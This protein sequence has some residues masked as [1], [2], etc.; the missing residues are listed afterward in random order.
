MTCKVWG[1]RLGLQNRLFENNDDD[2]NDDNDDCNY[3]DVMGN[4]ELKGLKPKAK[5]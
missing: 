4:W 2:C 1:F 5:F 3:D